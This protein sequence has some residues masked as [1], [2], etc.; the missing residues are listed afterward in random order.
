VRIFPCFVYAIL[1]LAGVVSQLEAQQAWQAQEPCA[2]EAPKNELRRR[3]TSFWRVVEIKR[4]RVNAWPDPFIIPDRQ[5]VRIPFMTQADIGWKLQTTLSDHLFD[6]NEL[7][8]AGHLKLRWILTQIPPHR[9]RIYVLEGHTR[10]ETGTRVASVFRHLA[11]I[12]PNGIP[13]PVLVTQVAPRGGDGGY[14]N[15]IDQ[16][17]KAAIA[18]GALSLGGATSSGTE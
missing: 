15:I 7:T 13:C 9:R 18:Q 5:L 12:A 17:H 14:L 11:D 2:D 10:D 1:I 16:A 8:Y 6:E 3:W 4:R